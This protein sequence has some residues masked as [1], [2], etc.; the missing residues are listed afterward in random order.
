MSSQK[1]PGEYGRRL[2]PFTIDT[3]SQREPG[4]QWASLPRDDDNLSKGYL[5]VSYAAFANAINRMA[6]FIE[7][8]VGR[9]EDN[10][11]KC[12]AYI[13][14]PDTRY[15]IM[16]MA[17]AKTGNMLRPFSSMWLF[18]VSHFMRFYS[19]RTCIARQGISA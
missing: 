18:P 1:L 4:R 13:G 2:L 15:H 5:D 14:A 11:P 7:K 12:I 6:F 8:A 19:P 16:S 10:A 3:I 9:A 17:T